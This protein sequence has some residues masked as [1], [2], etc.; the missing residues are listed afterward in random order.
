MLTNSDTHDQRGFTLIELMVVIVIAAILAAIAIPAYLRYQEEAHA[1]KITEHYDS[2]VRSVKAE[3]ARRVASLARGE[4]IEVL[5][6]GYL[7]QTLDPEGRGTAPLGGPA[8]VAGPANDVTGAVGISIVQ[9][10]SG[11][12]GL[13]AVIVGRPAFSDIV[14]AETVTLRGVRGP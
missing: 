8:Y 4:S 1:A 9:H 13:E 7:V 14:T 11:Q 5:N 2:A 3:F 10:A 6:E 12:A